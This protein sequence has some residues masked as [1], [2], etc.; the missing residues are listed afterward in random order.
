MYGYR[1]FLRGFVFSGYVGGVLAGLL[2]LN[3]VALDQAYYNAVVAFC[4]SKAN[5]STYDNLS[6]SAY[7]W[8][9]N[10]KG[11]S[12]PWDACDP[13]QPTSVTGWCN[14]KMVL[15][16]STAP[17]TCDAAGVGVNPSTVNFKNRWWGFQFTGGH[18]ASLSPSASG[19]SDPSHAELCGNINEARTFASKAASDASLALATADSAAQQ[20]DG[21]NNS[22]D[23]FSSNLDVKLDD[24]STQI[25]IVNTGNSIAAG[26]MQTGQLLAGVYDW[27]QWQVEE[28]VNFRRDFEKP[29]MNS[30]LAAMTDTNTLLSQIEA[31]NSVNTGNITLNTANLEYGQSV[32]TAAINAQGASLRDKVQEGNSTLVQIRN[33]EQSLNQTA[34]DSLDRLDDLVAGQAANTAAVA[35]A[36]QYIANAYASVPPP[37]VNVDLDLQPVV[38][39]L[40][41]NGSRI[42]AVAGAVGGVGADVRAG[43]DAIVA[44]INA[45]ASAGGSGFD[46]TPPSSPD[47]SGFGDGGSAGASE[48]SGLFGDVGEIASTVRNVGSLDSSSW[49]SGGS[50]SLPVISFS[51]PLGDFAPKVI[52]WD[53]S[54]LAGAMNILRLFLWVSTWLMALN[55]V[56]GSRK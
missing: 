6:G 24:L 46:A 5:Q 33:F 12:A 11:S 50:G 35:S 10:N 20:V 27:S 40:D 51:I 54:Q 45:N 52:T 17:S 2:P 19:C 21:F 3:A 55:I 25:N 38:S 1:S 36:A 41:A 42:D 8:I 7:T 32:N 34:D 23:A 4:S 22:I 37:V 30:M 39:A 47:L 48:A 53:F 26:T 13:T 14:V 56:L 16:D 44:A 18:C 28:D 9:F 15:C 49:L 29:F 31:K 43:T